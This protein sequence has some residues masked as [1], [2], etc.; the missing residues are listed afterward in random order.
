MNSYYDYK[1]D[2]TI[3]TLL[4]KGLFFLILGEFY[5]IDRMGI[6]YFILNISLGWME[7]IC[8]GGKKYNI[9]SY[10]CLQSIISIHLD[11]QEN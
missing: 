1:K 11:A 9:H 6:S 3:T 8:L 10:R 4:C 5:N 7:Q 2:Q